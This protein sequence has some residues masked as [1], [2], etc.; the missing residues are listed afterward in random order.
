MPLGGVD[1]IVVDPQRGAESQSTIRAADEHDVGCASAGRQHTAQH[2]NIVV[3]RTPGAVDREED[4]ASQ[5]ARINRA[6]IQQ[7]ATKVNN[8]VSVKRG[9]LASDLRVA[10]S[11]AAKSCASSPT[12]NKN[13]AVGIYIKG[14]VYGR[15]RNN[16]RRL[17]GDPAICGAL[18]CRVGASA[19]SAIVCLVLE[20]VPRPAGP[21]NGEPLLVAARAHVGR[22]LGPRLTAVGRAP[23]IVA[24]KRL[25]WPGRLQT[26]I[27]ESACLIG[28]CYR[29]AAENVV[30]QD[31]G[32]GPCDAGIG[33][34]TPATLPEVGSNVVKLPPGYCHLVAVCGV[35]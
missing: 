4:L 21:I 23:Q 33:R 18:E 22:L 1:A 15:V 26:E 32:K 9:C 25:I 13:V 29:V 20:A 30:L 11:H 8:G 27:E 6:R 14:P 28:L 24:V 16:D 19:V 34:V 10:R 12:T 35:N 2:V 3:S 17:P 7:A 31:P 5:A